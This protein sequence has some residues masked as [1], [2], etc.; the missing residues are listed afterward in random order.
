[1]AKKSGPIGLAWKSKSGKK[2][3]WAIML[4]SFVLCVILGSLLRMEEQKAR[5]DTLSN[6]ARTLASTTLSSGGAEEDILLKV[7]DL[8]NVD[9]VLGLRLL[10]GNDIPL[11]VGETDDT[12][13]ESELD[14][15]SQTRWS[16][17]HSQMDVA[18][19]LEAPLPF[20]VLVMR[21]DAD[22]QVTPPLLGTVINWIAAPIFA[23]I[24]GIISL[25]VTGSFFLKPQKNM[26]NYLQEQTGKFTSS[27]VPQ[28]L[29]KP[30]DD[31]GLLAKQIE[32]MRAEVI[33]SKQ[34]AEFQA[35]F[36]HETPYP[37]VRC[38]VNRKVMFANTAARAQS[39]LFGDETKEFVSP[40]VSELIRKSFQDA[41]QIYG[42]IRCGQYIITF[43]AIP[44]LDTGYVNLYGEVTRRIDEDI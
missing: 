3:A 43:R 29:T 42:D 10:K 6:F 37:L 21:L 8:L 12:F 44:I 5:Q 31:N 4:A 16:D 15:N 13:P 9:A 27:P 32:A 25:W 19:K 34:A 38:S 30:D 39:A 28:E 1:M 41:K 20:D 11:S 33:K 35:R 22:S 23:L 7:N 36:L 17:D 26:Q 40:A 18:F 24:S 14:Q 2:A